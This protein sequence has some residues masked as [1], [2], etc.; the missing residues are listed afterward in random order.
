ME[1]FLNLLINLIDL[2]NMLSNI[3]SAFTVLFVF[4]EY[5]VQKKLQSKLFLFQPR[6]DHKVIK[7][8]DID[9]SFFT[10]DFAYSS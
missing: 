10:C 7:N 5:S 3:T 4:Y 9:W 6:F 2:L 8:Y 1:I